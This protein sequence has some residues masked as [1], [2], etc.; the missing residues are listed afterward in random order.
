MVKMHTTSY[1]QL[2][3]KAESIKVYQIVGEGML[4]IFCP[5][6]V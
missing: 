2:N 6:I 1:T 5:Q 3:L 4:G